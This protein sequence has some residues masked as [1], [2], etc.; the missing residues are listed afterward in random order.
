MF[1]DRG[2]INSFSDPLRP[3]FLPGELGC[4]LLV[5]IWAPEFSPGIWKV[6]LPVIRDFQRTTVRFA[7][8]NR[9]RPVLG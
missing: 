4:Y 9:E 3:K 1:G 8:H 6:Q 7:S 2:L 5:L